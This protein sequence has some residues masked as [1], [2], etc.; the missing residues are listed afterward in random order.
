MNLATLA[1]RNLARNRRRSLLTIGGVSVGLGLMH[2][3]NNF[4]SGS[5]GDLLDTAISTMAGH[6]V[7]QGEG[8]QQ[9]R[10]SA[11]T[12]QRS[13]EVATALQAEFPD[14]TVTRR[15]MLEGLLMS[16]DNAIG[17]ML[18][19][20]EPA[21]EAA[22]SDLDDKLVAGTWL[23]A[24]N[25]GILIGANMAEA[26]GVSTGDKL[27]FMAQE[28]GSREGSAGEM[29]SRL[30][31]VKG[32]FKTG[33]NEVDGFVAYGTLAAAAE[34]LGGDDPATQVALHLDDPEQ[35]EAATAAVA[36]RLGRDDVEVLPWQVA[37]AELN[38]F[39][40]LDAAYSDAMF[41]IIGLMVAMGV[42]NTI[43]MSVLERT[44]ELGVMLALGLRPARLTA[45]VLLEGLFIGLIGAAVGF[46]LGAL[47]TWPLVRYGVDFSE[48][49]GGSYETAGVPMD[50]HIFATFNW[51][52]MG[53]YS[54]IAVIATVLASVW[55]AWKTSRL[56]PV[57]AIHH[58]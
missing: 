16:P 35:T 58:Q 15:T 29:T 55:P 50:T 7:V 3:S 42:L 27:V 11:I 40:Q 23:D 52:R 34:V 32:V 18:T 46:G 9:S 43:L 14:A 33:S 47:G 38:E 30:F 45:L 13:G 1:A 36:A 54:L 8:W 10:E 37:L 39:L 4:A 41:A 24:D 48:E 21:P 51:E 17:A 22:V 57:E 20:V 19:A 28:G 6:V 53:L 44:R 12:V 26:L 56:R 5:Y 49:F 2:T 25:R 31:R